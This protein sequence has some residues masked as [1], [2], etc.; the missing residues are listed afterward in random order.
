MRR[1]ERET[2]GSRR[3]RVRPL[4]AQEVRNLKESA[5]SNAFKRVTGTSPLHYRHASRATT[6]LVASAWAERRF[7]P[8]EQRPYA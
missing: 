5:F 7:G 6:T 2:G 1:R 3:A 4:Q 8:D